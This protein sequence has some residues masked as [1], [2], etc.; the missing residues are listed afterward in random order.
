LLYG[1]SSCL[2]LELLLYSYSKES[3]TSSILLNTCTI[4]T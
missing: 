3:S 2:G 4:T 1:P